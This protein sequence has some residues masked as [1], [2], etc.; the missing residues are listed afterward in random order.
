[1]TG[2]SRHT[3]SEGHLKLH[4]LIS[5]FSLITTCYDHPQHQSQRDLIQTLVLTI[6]LSTHT[7][8]FWN[9]K[10]SETRN[11]KSPM[12]LQLICYNYLPCLPPHPTTFP[13]LSLIKFLLVY[14]NSWTPNTSFVLWEQTPTHTWRTRQCCQLH[15]AINRLYLCNISAFSS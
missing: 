6:G 3:A 1:M 4:I 13:T 15:Q 8:F 5:L 10:F 2:Q 11:L 14:Q 7:R 9:Q 12:L